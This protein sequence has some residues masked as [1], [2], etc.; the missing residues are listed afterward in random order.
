MP[1][2]KEPIPEPA[3]L[4][5]NEKSW[6]EIAQ[7]A[8][9][10]LRPTDIVEQVPVYRYYPAP[11]GA[12]LLMIV[13][14]QPLNDTDIAE[15]TK[16]STPMKR[17]PI[18][19][20]I[21]PGDPDRMELRFRLIVKSVTKD[22]REGLFGKQMQAK[23]NVEEQWMVVPYLFRAGE[24]QQLSEAIDRISSFMSEDQRALIKN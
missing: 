2:E 5:K 3:E 6:I 15:A 18:G 10:G 7:Q 1:D 4:R 9:D 21:E 8:A 19:G 12:E 13:P 17:S 16:A 14:M 11:R 23:F 24:S 20:R 22:A